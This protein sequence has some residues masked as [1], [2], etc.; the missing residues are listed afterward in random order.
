MDTQ[1]LME[2][3]IYIEA[4][5]E[6]WRLMKRIYADVLKNDQEFHFLFESDY[7]LIRFN[8][9]NEMALREKVRLYEASFSDKW[10]EASE[11]VEKYKDYFATLLHINCIIALSENELSGR[12]MYAFLE[13]VTHL[14]FLAL[15][16]FAETTEESLLSMLALN[17]AWREGEFRAMRYMQSSTGEHQQDNKK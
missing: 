12:E 13:R 7:L 9:E 10:I 5:R 11:T 16:A 3:K 2:A 15:L 14:T 8:R 1:A 4:W 6:Q 17:R